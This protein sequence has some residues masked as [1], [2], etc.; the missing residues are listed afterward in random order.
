MPSQVIRPVVGS[1][2]RLTMRS[3]VVLPQPEGPT[4]TVILSEGTVRLRSTT[5][6]VPSRNVLPTDSNSITP[7]P[8]VSKDTKTL[9]ASAD[10]L[11]TPL[12]APR[13][14][15]ASVSWSSPESRS[16]VGLCK[17]RWTVVELGEVGVA[18]VDIDDPEVFLEV[19]Q[20]RRARNEQDV[21]RPGQQPGEPDLGWASTPDVRRRCAPRGRRPPW[22]SG[23]RR[24][25]REIR[26]KRD[27][28]G[29]AVVEYAA[30]VLVQ[31]AVGVLNAGDLAGYGLHLGER[32]GR[33]SDTGDLAL[34]AQGDHLSQLILDRDILAGRQSV[35]PVAY[36]GC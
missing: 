25:E 7:T 17:I 3:V 27:P 33:D 1:S 10:N 22:A 14:R 31:Q 20:R 2:I 12:G 13:L 19:G 21:V 5:A 30:V 23:E 6:T 32:R 26:D 34:I 24:A 11:R 18:E 35:M 36:G 9:V 8:Q 28:G 15:S 16:A 4:I 29:D